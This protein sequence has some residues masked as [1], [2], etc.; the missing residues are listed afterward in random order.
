MSD[1]DYK[2]VAEQIDR[3][4]PT[5][6]KVGTIIVNFEKLD[7][8]IRET[9]QR[10]I[11]RTFEDKASKILNSDVSVISKNTLNEKWDYEIVCVNGH[12]PMYDEQKNEYFCP[13]CEDN[14]SIFDY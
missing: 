4:R 6:F 10:R 1:L 7:L 12:R 3:E 14:R 8:D 2:E 5:G 13:T 9:V 11:M